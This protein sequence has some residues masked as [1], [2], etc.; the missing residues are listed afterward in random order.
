MPD[1]RDTNA[2]RIGRL[3]ASLARRG[4]TVALV[5]RG[6]G[7]E[8]SLPVRI[9]LSGYNTDRLVSEVK[10]T[11]SKFIMSPTQ[12]LAGSATWPGAA[13]GSQWPVKGDYFA[14]AGEPLRK[15]EQ[16]LP[17]DING[18]TRIEGRVSG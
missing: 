11:D 13:G 5:R 3:D 6:N 15:I 14:V 8:V 7:V 9:R 10:T 17:I 12:I 4:Q 2:A 1:M 16:A 18:V